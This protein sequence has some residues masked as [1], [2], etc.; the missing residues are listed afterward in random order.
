[1]RLGFWLLAL[2]LCLGGC[3]FKCEDEI[4]IE[5]ISPNGEYVATL[6]ERD[7]GATTDFATVV[8]IRSKSDKFVGGDGVVFVGKGQPKVEIMWSGDS[9]LRIKCGECAAS[10]VFKEERQW[11][12]IAVSVEIN[13]Q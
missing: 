10:N 5:A 4:K 11:K 3:G 13:N 2:S 8:N 7:C 9:A 12:D 1:M 6:F